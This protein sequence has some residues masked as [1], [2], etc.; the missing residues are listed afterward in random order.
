MNLTCPL[1]GLAAALIVGVAAPPQV[2]A[3]AAGDWEE[4]T[5]KHRGMEDFEVVLPAAKSVWKK[6]GDS[7]TVLGVEFPVEVQGDLKFEIDSNGDE[8]VDEA[9]KGNAGYVELSGKTEAG[10]SFRYAVR[11][12]NDGAKLWSW[13][14]SHVMQGKVRGTTL[15]FVDRNGNG[16]YDDLGQDAYVIGNDRGAAYLSSV[17]NIGGDLFE[18]ELDKSGTTVKTRPYTGATGT[19]SAAS[20]EGIKGDLVAAVFRSGANSFNVAGSPKGMKVPA[21]SYALESGHLERGTESATIARG[22]MEAIEVAADATATVEWGGPLFGE[23]DEPT[24]T[25]DKVTVRPTLYIF[26]KAGESYGDF[27]PQG[28]SPKVQILDKATG[29]VL[30]K[31]TFPSG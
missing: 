8:T 27:L 2:S 21:G 23:L 7:I 19:L 29:K 28:K 12:R 18:L 22:R 31:G 24:V 6:L 3:Q 26:G 9:V 15:S 1:V 16:R 14:P 25:K 17:V 5:L 11:F 10:E 4:A 20:P 13:M 30:K